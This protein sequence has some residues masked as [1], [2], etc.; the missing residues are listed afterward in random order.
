MT[1][2][3]LQTGPQHTSSDHHTLDIPIPLPSTLSPRSA[4]EKPTESKTPQLCCAI[5]TRRPTPLVLLPALDTAIPDGATSSLPPPRTATPPERR[6]LLTILPY[7]VASK[8]LN[9]YRTRLSPKEPHQT[10]HRSIA[11]ASTH[12]PKTH[13]QVSPA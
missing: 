3:P 13:A 12:T 2:S 7:S 5:A 10:I 9:L 1:A 8:A 4:P 6:L 11:S